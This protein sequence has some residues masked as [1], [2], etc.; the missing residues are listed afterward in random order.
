MEHLGMNRSSYGLENHGITKAGKV[1]WNLAPAEL[2]EIEIKEGRGNLTS[3]GAFLPNN[4]FSTGRS[5][6]DKYTVEEPESK[7]NIWWGKVNVPVKEEIFDALH[8]Q[9]V[10]YLSDK[11]IFV[12]DTCVGAD[13]DHRMPLR[14]VNEYGWANLFA[15][16]VFV[17][18]TPEEQ[19]NA[20]PEFTVLQAPGC[21]AD[22]EKYGLN[23]GTFV[24]VNFAK[25]M[26]II[27]GT[28]Y[29]G[30]IKKSI[31][32]VMNYLLP[33]KGVLSMHC[34]A[35]VSEDGNSAIFFGLSGTGKT[36]LS[37]DPNRGLIGDDEHGWTEKGIFNF[38]GGCYA[39]CINLSKEFEPQIYN[40]IRFGAILENLVMDEKTRELDYDDGS[41]TENTRAAYPL[42]NIDNA[43]LPSVCEHPKNIIF[44]TCDAF[45]VLPPVARLNPSQAM[46]HFI[47]GYTAKV[48][49][50]ERGVTEPQATFSACF[51][52]PFLP[53]HPTRYAELLADKMK[54]HGATLWL[55]NTGWSGGPYGVG[56]RMRIDHTRA[57]VHAALDGALENVEFEKFPIFE[58]EI[59]KQC[60]GVPNDVLNPKNTWDNK[61]AYDEKAKFLAQMF[62]D[63]FEKFKDGASQE[64]IDAAPKVS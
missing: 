46:Y 57:I 3:T 13:P 50:T 47:S 36:T 22:A 53:L 10:E 23:S 58:F 35:N 51:G 62:N 38:E 20:V 30:E 43:I 54:Q 16:Q 63:N 19:A 1:Y 7:D 4:A 64:I 48:A 14:V 32:S 42:T 2:V 45:G 52:A 41:I 60:P 17:N 25:R 6:F 5:P 18:P 21:T 40:A 59:P 12:L 49:G 8:K 37:A 15:H 61:D 9:I 24:I 27:G 26:V 44:L 39:K 28:S 55:I 31:F 29:A 34:S 33:L 11:D 56:K